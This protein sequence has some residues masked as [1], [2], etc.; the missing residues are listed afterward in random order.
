MSEKLWD[1]SSAERKR[2]NE[3]TSTR[4]FAPNSLISLIGSGSLRLFKS[5]LTRFCFITNNAIVSAKSLHRMTSSPQLTAELVIYTSI[6]NSWRPSS[7]SIQGIRTSASFTE[8]WSNASRTHQRQNGSQHLNLSALTQIPSCYSPPRGQ[9]RGAT[10]H[11]V[12]RSNVPGSDG[13][14]SRIERGIPKRGPVSY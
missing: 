10:V 11:L 6:S 4:V 2:G 5:E 9:H 8:T 1:V 14:P 3:Y 12:R 7:G 13:Y